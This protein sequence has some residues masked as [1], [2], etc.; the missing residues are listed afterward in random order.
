MDSIEKSDST[1]SVLNENESTLEEIRF[2]DYPI[3]SLDSILQYYETSGAVSNSP[4]ARYFNPSDSGL[5]VYYSLFD[6]VKMKSG[7]YS[8]DEINIGTL[9]THTFRK[10]LYGWS[11]KDK[12]QTFILLKSDGEL[13]KIGKSIKV[14]S[15]TEELIKELGEPIYQIDSDL[16]FLGRNNVIGKFTIQ[17]SIVKSF[18]YGR[19]NLPEK[20]FDTDSIKRREII[21]GKLKGL[22]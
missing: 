9:T 20:V 19:F 17:N 4:S 2:F 21:E 3:P 1:A 18:V 22:K 10:P 6:K 15:Y 7:N 5:Y 11:E 12:D 13:L 8:F 16:V 14:G